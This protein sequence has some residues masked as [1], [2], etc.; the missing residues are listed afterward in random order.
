MVILS[1]CSPKIIPA[2]NYDNDDILKRSSQILYITIQAQKDK[3]QN[4]INTKIVQ[5][6]ISNG[7]LKFLENDHAIKET[8]GSWRICLMDARERII[9]S[10]HL[11]NPF[12]FRTES[13]NENGYIQQ[14]STNIQHTQIPLRFPWL[15]QMKI[16]Q[17]DTLALSGKTDRIFMQRID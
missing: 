5:Y 4:R 11:E 9:Y 10:Q 8:A 2:V 1:A 6:Q 12:N 3:I 14:H 13:F 17:I 7:K 16:I 15:K